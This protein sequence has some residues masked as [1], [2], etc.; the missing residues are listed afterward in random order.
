MADEPDAHV[1]P[2]KGKVVETTESTH[3]KV[4]RPDPARARLLLVDDQPANLVALRAIL[5]DSGHELLTAASGEDALK[6]ALRER[7]TVVLLDVVMSGMDGFEVA[8]H[9]KE[10][11][12][13]RDIPILF[14]TALATDVKQIYRA[15]DVGAVDYIVKPL[16]P[17]VVRRKVGVLVKL[18]RQR[19]QIEQQATALREIDRREHELKL[20]ELRMAGDRRYRKL[21]EGIDHAVGWTMNEALQ[22][23]FISRQAEE[24]FGFPLQQFLEPG[25]WE[26]HLHPGDRQAMLDIFRRAL[27]EGVDFA[28]N[29]RM[30]AT[31]GRTFWFH[32]G[33]SGERTTGA[34]P[35]LHGIS[36][37]V[38][39]L[40]RAEEEARARRICARNFSPSW[41]TTF[42][43]RSAPFGR[44]PIYWNAS[45]R[46]QKSRAWRRS[47]ER[48]FAPRNGWTA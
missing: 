37:D 24:M 25:F 5:E 34:A 26:S 28:A 36:V 15:Y 19:E 31:E 43:I 17:E 1:E 7:L 42:E 35:E 3:G 40:K 12:R 10:L 41:R 38:T 21:I 8:R 20:A 32:T 4:T 33:V 44:A 48:S 16:D 29:H 6:I 27:A 39:D 47:L 22:F 13:T 2:R 23:T 9:L 18:V 11:E 46:A 30:L 14:L 45:P